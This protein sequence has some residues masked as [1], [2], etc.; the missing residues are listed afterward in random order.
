MSHRLRTGRHGV[1][2]L[3]SRTLDT[4]FRYLF[5]V[6][7]GESHLPCQWSPMKRLSNIC[8]KFFS[9]FLLPPLNSNSTERAYIYILND[10]Q[11]ATWRNFDYVCVHAQSL[12]CVQLFATLWTVACQT[13]LS[14]KNFQ[15][16]ILEW[17]AISY[18]R[19]SSQPRVQNHVSCSG[20][21]ILDQCAIWEAPLK[22]LY[23]SEKL[24]TPPSPHTHISWKGK[25]GKLLPE[26]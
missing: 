5:Q 26:G 6:F 7:S 16:R 23:L 15:A 3:I 13:P 14:M 19:G 9:Q 22:W 4:Y 11:T 10:I 12:G 2:H 25:K 21:Q 8:Y 18:S 20:K 17:I 24:R 1:G